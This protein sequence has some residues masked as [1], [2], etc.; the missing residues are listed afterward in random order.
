MTH[1]PFYYIFGG[2]IIIA[3]AVVVYMLFFRH[4]KININGI[5]IPLSASCIYK[6]H[7]FDD[8]F[9]EGE[10]SV[11]IKIAP[12]CGGTGKVSHMIQK[13]LK[14]PTRHVVVEPGSSGI[15]NHGDE[16]LWKNKEVYQDQ[17]TIIKK[18]ADD[19]TMEDLLPLQ[20]PPDCLFVDC[21]GCLDSFFRTPIGKYTLQ[22]VRIIVN[23]MDGFVLGKDLDDGLRTLWKNHGFRLVDIGY[24]CGTECTTEVWA[25][26]SYDHE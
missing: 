17:Y 10:C 20:G 14:Y 25:K 22:N 4:Q 16:F 6:G 13:H 15:G 19:L 11:A 7:G 9:E 21:E 23:E 3:I 8:H 5:T 26:E 12:L 1:I 18:F 2:G 24:G